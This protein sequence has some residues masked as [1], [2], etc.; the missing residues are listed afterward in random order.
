MIDLILAFFGSMLPAVLYNVDKKSLFWVGLSGAAG[1]AAYM[2]V[3][4]ATGQ[5]VFSTFAGAVMVG[6]YSESMARTIKQPATIFSAAGMFP[7]VPGIGAYNTVQRIVENNLAEAAGTGI[8]TVA[9]A[10]A[11]ALGIM[12]VSVTFRMFPKT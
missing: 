3:F 7:L 1:W 10:G 9:S 4:G 6:L 2:L 8:E 12:L 11:I 5:V